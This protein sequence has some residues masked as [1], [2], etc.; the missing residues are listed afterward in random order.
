MKLNDLMKLKLA[1]REQE[2][3]AFR[4]ITITCTCGKSYDCDRAGPYRCPHCGKHWNIDPD[5]KE[6]Q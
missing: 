5:I 3:R 4:L 1:S 2:R 6:T